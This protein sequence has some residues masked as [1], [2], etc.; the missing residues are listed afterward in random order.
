MKIILAIVTVCV[1]AVSLPQIALAQGSLAGNANLAVLITEPA[2]ATRSDASNLEQP[3]G[4]AG[5]GP[6]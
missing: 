1:I 6:G 3:H 4:A 5:A 2:T